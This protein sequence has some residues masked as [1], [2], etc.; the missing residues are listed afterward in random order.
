[1]KARVAK[2]KGIVS[3]ILTILEGIPFGEFYFEIA[4]VLRNALLVSSMLCNS[5]CW[6]NV[7]KAELDLLE[8]IDVQ[9]LRR[10]L[11]VPKS[12]PKEMLYLELGCVPF[13]QL[14]QK[15]RILFLHY[16]LNES[17]E[18]LM[19]RFLQSQILNRKKKDWITQVLTDIK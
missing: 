8:T 5:E 14:I 7:T 3:R 13:R 1:M 6:Y 16:I 11:K 9:F 19:Y 15:R 18:S 4:V 17:N 12:T 2:G 10:T